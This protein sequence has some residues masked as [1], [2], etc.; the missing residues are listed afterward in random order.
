[1]YCLYKTLPVPNGAALG[2]NRKPLDALRG[3]ALRPAGAASVA[4]RSAELLLERLRSRPNGLGAGL[5]RAKRSLGRAM[6]TWGVSRIPIG[7]MGFDVAHVNVAMSRLCAG[8][9]DRFDYGRIRRRRRENAALLRE[10]I[11]E[12]MILIKE[13]MADG[14]CPLF[15][16][17][18]VADKREA[19]KALQRRGIGAI[20]CWNFGHPGAV[21]GA[22]AEFLR[23]HVL[24]LPIHQDI[25]VA[26][27]EYMASQVSRLTAA[28]LA[29]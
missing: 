23:R 4:G 9:L 2:Q 12:S 19:A 17:I 13:P 28:P 25:T 1:V 22:D 26:Q 11:P 27:V 16:P 15:F 24:E 7:D 14:V 8:L 3:L 21:T 10:R 20:E 5:M 29:G 18:V 6:T